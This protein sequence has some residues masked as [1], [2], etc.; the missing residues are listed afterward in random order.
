[1]SDFLCS[2]DGEVGRKQE[3]TMQS[4]C[5]WITAVL[6]F[7]R[8]RSL[9]TWFWRLQSLRWC[10]STCTMTGSRPSLPTQ[11]VAT[12][13]LLFV[14]CS[15]HLQLPSR[16]SDWF[17]WNDVNIVMFLMCCLTTLG[18]GGVHLWTRPTGR[19]HSYLFFPECTWSFISW[20]QDMQQSNY[21]G[22]TL[23]SRASF[24][25]LYDMILMINIMYRYNCTGFVVLFLF[26]C[27]YIFV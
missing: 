22:S 15:L 9:V 27:A 2:W 5:V 19:H 20:V 10:C 21:L 8:W 24:F 26:A 23:K 11:S 18:R 25:S 13:C 4:K 3:T 7:C 16:N 17:S 12:L 14:L 1:M 6:L